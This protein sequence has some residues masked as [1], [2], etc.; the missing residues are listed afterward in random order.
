MA[1]S[2]VEVC[3]RQPS[4]EKKGAAV[5]RWHQGQDLGQRSDLV[6]FE[7]RLMNIG[8]FVLY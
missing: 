5:I 7:C 1:S 4:P 6:N 3:L 8:E 2:G